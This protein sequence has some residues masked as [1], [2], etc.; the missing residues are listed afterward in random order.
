M[1]NENESLL[2]SRIESTEREMPE[3]RRENQRLKFELLRKETGEFP[4]DGVEGT[5]SGLFKVRYA[6]VV[7]CSFGVYI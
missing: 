3:L 5:S 4:Q 1:A 2:Q 6:L 7:T